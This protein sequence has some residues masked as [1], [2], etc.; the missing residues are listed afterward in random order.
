MQTISS[1]PLIVLLILMFGFIAFALLQDWRNS[2]IAKNCKHKKLQKISES[3]VYDLDL[4][5]NHIVKLK[6][7]CCEKIIEVEK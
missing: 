5:K 7:M 2:K 4:N 3:V 1:D 6:C